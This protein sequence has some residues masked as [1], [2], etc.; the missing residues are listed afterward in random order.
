MVWRAPAKSVEKEGHRS[1]GFKS[2]EGRFQQNPSG[3]QKSGWKS[4]YQD[5][6]DTS[7]RKEKEETPA[8]RKPHRAEEDS[9]VK[10]KSEAPLSNLPLSSE[11]TNKPLGEGWTRVKNPFSKKDEK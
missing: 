9:T 8:W 1:Y 11:E 4:R 3:E 7:N 6:H 10:E 5:R 2:S